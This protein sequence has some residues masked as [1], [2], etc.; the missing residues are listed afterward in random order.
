MV[1]C[2]AASSF[3]QNEKILGSYYMNS[4]NPEGGTTLFVMPHNTFV[5]AYFGGL[6]KGNWELKEDAYQFTYHSEPKVVLYERHNPRLKDSISVNMSV[7]RDGELAVRF[8]AEENDPFTPVFNKDANCMDYPYIYKQKEVLINLIVHV[9][10]LRYGYE[11]TLQDLSEIYN[12][13]NAEGLNEF[14]LAGLSDEYS[15]GGTFQA[16]YGNGVLTL[17]GGQ[18]NLKKSGNYEDIDPEILGFITQHTEM[19]MFPTR[20]EYGH[21]FFPY[22]EDPKP[23]HLKPFKRIDSKKS[24]AKKHQDFRQEPL[25]HDL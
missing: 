14:I 21:E 7:D 15:E 12:F 6:C 10:D 23:K 19:E 20:L 4:G 18:D 16:T 22:Y 11:E 17:N 2:F 25:C 24:S 13:K 8:N 9:P 5:V 3:S 1:C